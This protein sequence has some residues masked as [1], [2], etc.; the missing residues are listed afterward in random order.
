MD[1]ECGNK[2]CKN[3]NLKFTANCGILTLRKVSTCS[4]YMPIKKVLS[5]EQQ[6]CP[7]CG[8]ATI[9]GYVQMPVKLTAENGAKA[10]LMGEFVVNNH[11]VCP[12]CNGDDCTCGYCNGTGEVTQKVSIPWIVIKDIYAQAMKLLGT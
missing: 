12:K 2:R 3:F 11:L 7:H 10:A 9:T 4:I 5:G 1:A 8:H 6:I